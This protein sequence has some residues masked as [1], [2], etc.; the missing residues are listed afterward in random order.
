MKIKKISI[1]KR[2][3]GLCSLL[4]CFFSLT[5][6][7]DS[8]LVSADETIGVFSQVTFAPWY[9]SDIFRFLLF[10]V[11]NFSF[12]LFVVKLYRYLSLKIKW[13]NKKI[14][15][16]FWIS[17]G[18][19]LLCWLPY[20]LS[21]FPGGVYSDTFW[22]A[23]QLANIS[24]NGFQNLTNHHP[25]LYTF[26]VKFCTMLG[27][28]HG[29]GSLTRGFI[30]Y[31]MFQYFGCAFSISYFMHVLNKKGLPKWM[32]YMVLSFFCIY[33]LV[34]LYVISLWKD[35]VFNFILIVYII[36]VFDIAT[37]PKDYLEQKGNCILYVFLSLLVCFFRNNGIYIVGGTTLGLWL[38]NFREI[39]KTQ[40]L[41]FVTSLSAIIFTIIVQG[42]VFSFLNL[43]RD[44]AVES[45]AIP[46]QQMAYTIKHNDNIKQDLGLI[47]SIL[48]IE[49][50]KSSYVPTNFDRIK[51]HDN[52][53]TKLFSEKEKDFLLLWFKLLPKNV[54][55]YV[56]AYLLQTLGYWN[57]LR[58]SNTAYYQLTI[59]PTYDNVTQKD[60]FY[61]ITHI[62]FRNIIFSYKCVSA[63]LF[64]WITLFS[65]T[66]VLINK[67]YKYILI[68]LPA[69]LS[70]ATIMLA[71]PIAFSLRYVY[72]LVLMTPLNIL[73]PL[74]PYKKQ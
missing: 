61:E 37:S 60:F 31:Q 58:S 64:L 14:P 53:N 4:A 43:N 2:E 27:G 30:V 7:I 25:I 32:L 68:Y 35:T 8:K 24:E 9:I 12:S 5:I 38:L 69:L 19:L 49:E 3:I 17:M 41:F 72:I 23:Y 45:L 59:W 36:N 51:W 48:P 11:I 74:L 46:F 66:I 21:Y 44:L 56:E 70:W 50:I 22:S 20:I 16:L 71:T 28:W 18:L 6:L 47:D 52:F 13:N 57:V 67:K 73:V 55:N 40:R 54:K 33:P 42:P 10:V 26:F 34:P 1:S 15:K 63:A 39:F 65:L 29:T 62:S